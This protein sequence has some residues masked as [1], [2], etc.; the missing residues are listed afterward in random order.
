MCPQAIPMQPEPD[1]LQVTTWFP[2]PLTC[3]ENCC[4]APGL[5]ETEDGETVTTIVAEANGTSHS[6]APK[7]LRMTNSFALQLIAS[8]IRGPSSHPR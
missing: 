7:T 8:P 4:C 5:I 2:V 3:A 1:R 6:D